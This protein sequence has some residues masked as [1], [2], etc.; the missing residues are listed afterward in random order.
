MTGRRASPPPAYRLASLALAPPLA[1]YTLYRA[2]RDGGRA[3]LA[4]RYGFVATGLEAPVWIHCASVGEV[5]AAM[6]LLGELGDHGIGPLL[7]T[8][9]TP[10]GQ[11]LARA[12]LPAGT[13]LAYLPLDR[14][15]P[16]RRFLD[17]AGPR[18]ALI[19]ETELWPYLYAGLAR[20]GVPIAL[21][22]GR[23]SPRTLEAPAWWRRAAAWCL[24]QCER[25]LARSEADR[26]RFIDLGAAPERVVAVGNIKFAAAAGPAPEPIALGRAFVLAASTHDDEELQLARAWRAGG[27]AGRVLAIAPRHPERGR[28]IA[29]ALADEGFA[30]SRRSRHEAPGAGPEAI[31]LADTLGELAGLM[32]AADA[33]IMGGSFIPRGGQNVLEAARAG[34][35]VITGPHMHNFADETARLETAG[36]LIRVA[37]AAAAIERVSRLLDEP[38]RLADMGRAGRSLLE[39]ETDMAARYR[40]ALVAALPGLAPAPAPAPPGQAER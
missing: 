17:R 1:G 29:R 40:R 22:N 7:V 2:L 30:V 18:A 32:A 34:R 31:H 25:V 23:L 12:R 15:G 16:V 24:R 26:R 33:V 6:P 28:S 8:T 37:D 19:L 9:A 27:P 35:A 11:A 5:A 21:V 38:R 10:T 13:G 3:Y 39:A 4:G 36:A 14:P 20:R